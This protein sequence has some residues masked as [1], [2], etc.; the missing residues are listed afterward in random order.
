MTKRNIGLQ[1]ELRRVDQLDGMGE[2]PAI[3][4]RRPEE[5][6]PGN[7]LRLSAAQLAHELNS[8]L[9]G[10]LRSL[11][12]ACQALDRAER[13][14]AQPLGQALDKLRAAQDGLQSMAEV[15]ERAMTGRTT[16]SGLLGQARTFSQIVER[17]V[18]QIRESAEAH[19]VRLVVH[20]APETAALNAGPLEPVVLNGL[21]NAVES[22]ISSE[23]AQRRVELSVGPSPGAELAILISDTGAGL[24]DDFCIGRSGKAGGHG[25][26]LEI[27][28]QIVADLGGRVSLTNVPFGTGAV[29]EVRIP[30]RSLTSS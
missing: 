24:P 3:K 12:L 30:R 8:L 13:A 26:G 14:D 1:R 9:D 15:L 17:A 27:V 2:E 22:C 5:K 18:G 7:G 25:L 16:P 4:T 29:L 10:S 28:H 20:L 21:R 11:A 6:K 23:G 19:D